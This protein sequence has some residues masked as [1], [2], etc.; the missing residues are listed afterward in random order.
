[1]N[2]KSFFRFIYKNLKKKR[3]I[4]LFKDVKFS[5]LFVFTVASLMKKIIK[6]KLIG[7]FNFSSDNSLSKYDFGLLVASIFR[8][9]K[10][11]IIASEIKNMNLTRRPKNMSLSNLKLRKSLNIKQKMTVRSEIL[12]L[13]KTNMIRI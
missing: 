2:K 9:N 4:F 6:K 11:L 3:K 10:K 5:P 12:K 7:I 8:L 1:M 13:K